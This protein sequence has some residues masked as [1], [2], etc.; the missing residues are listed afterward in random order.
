M[1]ENDEEENTQTTQ[2]LT[3]IPSSPPP[4]FRSRASSIT[5]HHLLSEDPLLSDVDRT[6]ADTFDDGSGSDIDR[7]DHGDDRQRIMRGNP[8]QAS[9]E[10]NTSISGLQRADTEVPDPTPAALGDINR[11]HSTTANNRFSSANDGVFANLN[12]KPERGEKTE[13][14][15]PVSPPNLILSS[16]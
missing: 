11:A 7:E 13:E 1:S 3:S 15:P 16:F 2:V 6:L 12:A 5:S 4:S 9:D 8:S 14:Q 10:R